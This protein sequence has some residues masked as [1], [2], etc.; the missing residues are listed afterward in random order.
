MAGGRTSFWNGI[1]SFALALACTTRQFSTSY[2]GR[3][4]RQNSMP[5]RRPLAGMPQIKIYTAC[6][7][8]PK[9]APCSPWLE[10][11]RAKHR[12]REQDTN[13]R[14]GQLFAGN[15]T[16]VRRVF[17]GGHSGGAHQDDKHA[18]APRPTP[19]RIFVPQGQLPGPSQRM[20]STGRPNRSAIRG[21]YPPRPSLGVRPH[22]SNPSRE[23]KIRPCRHPPYDGGYLRRQLI[24]F[25][26]IKR[27]RGTRRRNEGGGPGPHWYPMTPLRSIWA[28]QKAVPTPNQ[29]PAAAVEAAS[30]AS[31][32]TTTWSTSAKAAQTAAKQRWRR[33]RLCVVFI[34]QDNVP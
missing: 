23:E 25:R 20:Q 13:N 18:D 17:A 26:N 6:S 28:F 30:S 1:P 27:H 31:S 32:A 2:N 9:L 14:R 10:G 3:S 15:S 11:F 33:R 5:T 4:G 24:P 19:R 29:T 16:G 22:S 12:L 7:S 8:P 21:H 34:S